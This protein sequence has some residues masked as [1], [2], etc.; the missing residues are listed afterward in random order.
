M[1]RLKSSDSEIQTTLQIVASRT[2][3]VCALR[4]NTPRSSASNASTNRLKPTHSQID[5]IDLYLSYRPWDAKKASTPTAT[6]VVVVSP[7]VHAHYNQPSA[8]PLFYGCCT[9]LTTN[10]PVLRRVATPQP[11]EMIAYC[12]GF[13]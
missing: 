4:W 13:V 12:T 9:V 2:E 11:V 5:P 1:P 10:R 8:A 3:T 7:I 6:S